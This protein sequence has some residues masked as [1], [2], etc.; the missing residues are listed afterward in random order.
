MIHAHSRIVFPDGH[1]TD[2][3]FRFR[4]VDDNIC[5]VLAHAILHGGAFSIRPAT[6]AE[7]VEAERKVANV[8][9]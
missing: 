8:V 9:E 6:K 1:T 4:G 2:R 3:T 7:I 5:R